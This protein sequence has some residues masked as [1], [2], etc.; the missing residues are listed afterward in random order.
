VNTDQSAVRAGG[1]EPTP[2]GKL[3]RLGGDLF[4]LRHDA[5]KPY[6][7]EDAAFDW[8]YSEHFIEHVT[9]RDAV[10]WLREVRRL[11]APGGFARVTTPD[12]RRYVEGYLDPKASF[13]SEHARRLRNIG[14]TTVPPRRA[15]MLN[16]IFM[17]WGHR[18][19]Y[20][21]D[22]LRAA[23]VEAGFTAASVRQAGFRIGAIPEVAAMDQEHRSDESLYVEMFV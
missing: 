15:W 14:V 20:D 5:T 1:G 8:V 4:Y 2:V 23:A 6:P 21:Y 17:G 18:W 10:V 13:F 7:F 16:Q 12:L 22:E 19:L 11:L 3:V 9:R